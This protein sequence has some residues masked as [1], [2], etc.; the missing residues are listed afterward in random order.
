PTPF[1]R[2][3]LLY[4]GSGYV[5]DKLKPLYAIRPGGAGD[6]SLKDG[7]RANAHIAWCER[8]AAPYNPSPLAYGDPV[9]V[10]F[11]RGFLECRDARSGKEVYGR[12]RLDPAAAAFTASPWAYG[13]K[14]FCL[15]EDGDTFIIKAGPQHEVLATNSIE[16]PVFASPAISN[17]MIFIRGEKHL[18]CIGSR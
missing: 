15:S 5:M 11:D 4:V 9:Y 12:R 18:Y 6:I 2:S 17:G 8:D 16:E 1:E 10:L 3:G 7:E 14:I 13:G